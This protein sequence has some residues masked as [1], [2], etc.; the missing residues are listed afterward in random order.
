MQWRQFGSQFVVRIARGEEIIHTLTQF[1]KE[2]DIRA[3]SVT[4][5]GATNDAKLYYY[6]MEKQ[7]YL[8]KRFQEAYE[9]TSI[10]GNISL[11]NG[12]P[13]CHLHIILGD[14]KYQTF[15]G[16]L[17]SAN[18]SVTCEIIIDVLD[19]E[20]QRTLDEETGLKLLDL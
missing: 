10:M 17:H 1:C 2:Q 19:G 3:G 9:I 16:H 14:S 20:L 7:E 4:G 11:V 5:I 12:E 13:F 15:S 8:E 18:V 6:D